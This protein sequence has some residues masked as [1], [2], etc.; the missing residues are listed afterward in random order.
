M[1]NLFSVLPDDFFKPLNSKYKDQYA[2]CLL[3]IYNSYKTEISYGVERESVVSTLTDYFNTRTD[4]ISFDDDNSFEKDSRSK[5]QKT[6]NYLRNCGWLDFEEEKNYQQNVVLTEQAVPFIRTMN[7]VIKNE[8]TEYQGLISQ[9]HAVLQNED[10]YSKPY[11]FILKN[12]VNSTE[13]LVSSLKKLNISIKKHIDKQTKNKELSEIFSLFSVYNEEIVSKSLYRLKTSENIGKFRQSIKINLD[14]MLSEPKILKDL[15]E[16]YMEIE[17][18]TDS[19]LA[20][21][22]IIEMIIDV[23]SAFENLDKIIEDIDRKNNHYMKNAASRA[24]FELASGTN[25]EGKINAILRYLTEYSDED[26]SIPE[27]FFNVYVQKFVSEESIKKIPEK[28]TYEEVATINETEILTAEERAL[29]K[30]LL[31]DKQMARIYRKKIEDFV[32]ECLGEKDLILASDIPINN[33]KDFETL[34]Y[35]RLFAIESYVYRVKKTEQRIR[36]KNCEFTDFEIIKRKQEE[37]KHV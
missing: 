5:A 28:K 14:K 3:A 10:L 23:K 18:E 9:I 21:D 26:E 32:S 31:L 2:D 37:K 11:Q 29:K 20:K 17:Q 30:Q 27:N 35:I 8:E 36:T 33:R 25:Q 16:G 13:Q 15:V 1:K 19:E 24:K 22:K 4:D 34:I 6:I 12:V 7:D